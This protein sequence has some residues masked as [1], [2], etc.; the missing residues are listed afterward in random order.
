MDETVKKQL[1][2]VRDSGAVNMLDIQ[3]VQRCACEME[4]FELVLFIE[5]H[6]K[7]YIYFIFYGD[8]NEEVP[9]C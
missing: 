4:L 5:E 9:V 1:L 7:E 8:E 2:Q 3:A 6:R